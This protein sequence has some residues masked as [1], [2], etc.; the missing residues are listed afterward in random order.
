MIHEIDG[1]EIKQEDRDF[2][3]NDRC[4]YC[5][6]KY[7]DR[8]NIMFADFINGLIWWHETHDKPSLPTMG[9]THYEKKEK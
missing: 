5:Y 2:I 9:Y 1:N 7:D 6:K 8:S 4:V 3:R